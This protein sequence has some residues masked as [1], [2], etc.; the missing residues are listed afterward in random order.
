MLIQD[1]IQTFDDS[2]L[3]GQLYPMKDGE[4]F[5]FCSCSENEAEWKFKKS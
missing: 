2:S 1:V 4:Q 3:F 5:Q